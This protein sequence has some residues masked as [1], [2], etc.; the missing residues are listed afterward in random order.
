[1][2]D[3]P[4]FYGICNKDASSNN[5]STDSFFLKLSMPV[6]ASFV[7]LSIDDFVGPYHLEVTRDSLLTSAE[8]E[9]TKNVCH[10]RVITISVVWSN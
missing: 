1:M 7:F 9:G 5:P 10:P 3:C 6:V 4:W 8:A 2:G